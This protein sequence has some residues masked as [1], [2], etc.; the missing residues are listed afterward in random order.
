MKTILHGANVEQSREEFTRLKQTA[1]SVDLRELQGKL[2]DETQIT[3]ALD[4]SSLFGDEHV[5][6]CI[7][8]LLSPLGRKT[9]KLASFAAL[10]KSAS[11]D[12]T[13]ILWEPKELGKE[14]LSFFEPDFSVRLFAYPKIIFTFLDAL[15]PGNTKRCINLLSELLATEPAELVWSMV[16]TRIRQLIQLKDNITPERMSSW[17]VSRLTNQT[18]L[19]TMD[20]LLNMHQTLRTSEYQLK[21]GNSPYTIADYLQL[22]IATL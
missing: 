20:K 2:L 1:R 18:R 11:K 4:S 17:Q 7:E 22:L 15:G 5:V 9:T 16:I 19:F 6:I 10:L 8:N 12:H 14:A 21:Q 13:I 3:Q